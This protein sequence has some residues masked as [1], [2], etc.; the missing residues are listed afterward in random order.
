MK[1]NEKHNR[2]KFLSLGLLSGTALLTQS[3]KAESLSPDDEETIKM[4]TPDGVLVEVKK[5]IVNK[6]KT[7][8]KVSNKEIL[9]W[10][11][12]PKPKS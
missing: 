3:V 4:L 1:N 2:R 5:S 6:E 9:N 12:T 7:G 10:T 11:N 8:T